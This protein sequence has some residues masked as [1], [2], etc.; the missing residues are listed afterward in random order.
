MSPF[1]KTSFVGI[2]FFLRSGLLEWVFFFVRVSYEVLFMDFSYLY[3]ISLGVL[4]WV[5]V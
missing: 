4:F 1:K 2:S 5:L 3:Q